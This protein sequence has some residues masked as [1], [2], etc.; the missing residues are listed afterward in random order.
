MTNALRQAHELA[1]RLLIERVEAGNS[2]FAAFESLASSF[3]VSPDVQACT[4]VLVSISITCGGEH[5][6]H[7]VAF[8]VKG[9]SLG[10][11]LWVRSGDGA[12]HC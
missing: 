12:S 9:H 7:I 1:R 2:S 8:T 11:W 6:E 3:D 5:I 10:C 4:Y